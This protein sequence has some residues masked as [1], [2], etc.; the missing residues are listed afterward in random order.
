MTPVE[1]SQKN[2]EKELFS[3]L[4]DKRKSKYQKIK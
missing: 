1:A 2:I 3:I 4:Q